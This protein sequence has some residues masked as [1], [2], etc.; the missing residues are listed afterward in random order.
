MD[1]VLAQL[2]D[3]GHGVVRRTAAAGSAPHWAIGNAVAASEL[4]RVLPRTYVLAG[5]EDDPATRCRAALVYA[6]DASAL[7]HLTALDRWLVPVPDS[8][9]T[10]PVHITVPATRRLRPGGH[11]IVHRRKGFVSV[12]PWV[13]VRDGLAVVAFERALIE[14]WPMLGA[15]DRAGPLM[16]AVNSRRTTAARL[17]RTLDGLPQLAD[18][19]DLARMLGLID[20]GCRSWLEILGC[21]EIFQHP[22]LPKSRGQVPVQLGSRTVYLD[23][24]FDEELVAVELDGAE[25]HGSEEARERDRRRDAALAALGILVVRYT[26]R[27]LVSEPEAVRKELA[28]IL[29]VRRR[30][31]RS[32]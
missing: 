12:P 17:G 6:G 19:A 29:A 18:R 16:H 20:D 2:L 8:A 31:L 15:S 3:A 10:G 32:A 25:H 1:T 7:S 13:V 4:V 26:Y 11:V 5:L 21:L 22:S 30:Q 14:S 28:Q 9:K 23:R 27:R 24:L